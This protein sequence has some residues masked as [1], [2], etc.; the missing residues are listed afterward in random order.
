M[1]LGDLL[2]DIA[3]VLIGATLGPGIAGAGVNPF[4]SRAVTGAI[5]SK[6][7]G[8]KSKDAVRNALLAG[9]GGMAFD[10]FSGQQAPVE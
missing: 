1:N 10:N 2:K 4:I 9:I 6:L 7:T 3:P 5:T 8:G